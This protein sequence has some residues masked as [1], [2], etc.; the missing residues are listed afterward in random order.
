[1][2]ALTIFSLC[3]SDLIA[4]FPDLFDMKKSGKKESTS[5]VR[6]RVAT[7]ESRLGT[8]LINSDEA[9]AWACAVLSER[10]ARGA[11]DWMFRFASF[12]GGLEE[13]MRGEAIVGDFRLVSL[14]ALFQ[15]SVRDV[16]EAKG[17]KRFGD[18]DYVIFDQFVA[19]EDHGVANPDDAWRIMTSI[20]SGC[21]EEAGKEFARS[22]RI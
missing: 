22:L 8:P 13:K 3:D 12:Y 7:V 2:P 19:L 11:L 21:Y 9:D 16:A 10:G 5:L 15:D 14:V 18:T 6:L 17:L 20:T 4:A 1:M